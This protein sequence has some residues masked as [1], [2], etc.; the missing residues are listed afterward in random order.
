MTRKE[1]LEIL[2]PKGT[3]VEELKATYRLMAFKYH[4]DRGGNLEVM[5]LINLAYEFLLENSY[6]QEE[7]RVASGSQSSILD[8][9]LEVWGK[10]SGLPGISGEVVGTWLWVGGNTFLVKESLKNAGLKFSSNKKSWYWH[11]SSEFTSRR[12]FNL[13]ME[14]IRN[15]YG[16]QLLE[17]NSKNQLC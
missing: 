8:E 15:R 16:S 12:K 3:A 6:C 2:K 5:K 17:P 7:V 4:P 11:R 1:A 9:I 13:T 14:D 10:I